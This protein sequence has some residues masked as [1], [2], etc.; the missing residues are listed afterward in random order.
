MHCR[1]STID[2]D[3]LA[4]QR[5]EQEEFGTGQKI[6]TFVETGAI[7]F[8]TCARFSP[9]APLREIVSLRADGRKYFPE[10]G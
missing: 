9:N 8:E 3:G 2:A 1:V 10:V 5:R 4:L 7:G 6:M